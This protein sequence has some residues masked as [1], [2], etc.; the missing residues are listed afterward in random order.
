MRFYLPTVLNFFR[1]DIPRVIAIGDQSP[2]GWQNLEWHVDQRCS[3]C[4]WLGHEK[5]A[6]TNEKAKIQNNPGQLIVLHRQDKSWAIY[7][8]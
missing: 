7:A 2:N 5:W 3:A 8:N 4:D 1:E 6:N